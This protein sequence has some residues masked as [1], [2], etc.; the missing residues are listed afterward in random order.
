MAPGEALPD[1][2]VI[3]GFNERRIDHSK[4]EAAR[5]KAAEALVEV[6]KKAE[7]AI[8]AAQSARKGGN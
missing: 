6:L 3:Y 2:T 5:A 7:M 1:Y 8:R 4:P